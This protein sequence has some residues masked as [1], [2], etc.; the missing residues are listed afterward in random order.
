[1][2]KIRLLGLLYVLVFTSLT[3]A[4]PSNNLCLG[5][6]ELTVKVTCN[7][8]VVMIDGTET[9]SGIANPGC[10][11]YAGGDLWYFLRIP[12]TGAVVV[13]AS[14]SGGSIDHTGLALYKGNDCNNLEF[15]LCNTFS[16]DGFFPRAG[17]LGTPGETLYIRV[18]EE[19]NNTTGT[20]NLCAYEVTPPA[21]NVCL[22]AVNIAV[23]STCENNLV[24]IDGSET[25]SKIANPG[26][27]AYYGGDL[28]YK[29]TIPASKTV[30]IQSSSNSSIDD[31][32]MA[33]YTTNTDCDNLTFLE[34]ND[35]GNI[36]SEGFE[37]ITLAEQEVGSVIYVRVWEYDNNYTGDFNICAFDPL[38]MG[39][40]N[41]ETDN[42]FNIFPN[43]AKTVVTIKLQESIDGSSNRVKIYDILGKLVSHAQIEF[44]NKV[45]QL[46]VSGLNRGIYFIQLNNG[47]KTSTKKLIIE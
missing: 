2:K 34:C 32:G 23:D 39:I 20:F 22:G 38:A 45:S 28:W 11:N 7:N 14:S 18:W 15:E 17:I 8:S 31:T 43:P 13:E 24:T 6:I 25:Y 4:Q 40:S 42:L 35:D 37:E 44:E 10:A 19:G 9:N 26:C 16:G 1:M 36:D 12:L 27:A 33:V 3:I 21:N 30:V 47:Q 29:V 46:D 41:T 5:A